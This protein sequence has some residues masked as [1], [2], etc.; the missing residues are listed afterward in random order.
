MDVEDE[1]TRE[2]CRATDTEH[3]SELLGFYEGVPLTEQSLDHPPMLPDR[4][5]LYRRNIERTCNGRE[6]I[7]AEIRDTVL[8]E[9]GHHFGLD[10]DDLEDLGYG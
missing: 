1:P 3:P 8:H 4:I 10:E 9:I 6:E 5:I 2:V 7:I